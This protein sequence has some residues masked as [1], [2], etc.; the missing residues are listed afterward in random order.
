MFCEGNREV[1]ACWHNCTVALLPLTL[2]SQV[3][4]ID[5]CKCIGHTVD[6]LK[7]SHIQE[8]VH[9]R[10]DLKRLKVKRKMHWLVQS[11]Q[12]RFATGTEEDLP[13][14]QRRR[15]RRTCTE[16]KTKY[17]WGTEEKSGD[18]SEIQRSRPRRT[19]TVEKSED[20]GGTEEKSEDLSEIRRSRPRRTCTEKTEDGGGTDV[21][22]IIFQMYVCLTINTLMNVVCVDIVFQNT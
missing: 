7:T 15:P 9:G 17:S 10:R 1:T 19:C 6:G 2:M 20:G 22:C 13:E 16:E 14:I 3:L 5:P 11:R 18:L 21:I 12:R 4:Q 8:R